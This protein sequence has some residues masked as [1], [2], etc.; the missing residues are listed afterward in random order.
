MFHLDPPSL[1]PQL[2]QSLEVEGVRWW[3]ESGGFV[4]TFVT[5]LFTRGG[6]SLPSGT[7]GLWSPPWRLA[8]PP[9]LSWAQ[10]G[11]RS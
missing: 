11:V 6:Q 10:G 2:I 3:P 7:V 1:R 8:E 5:L 9:P 4:E